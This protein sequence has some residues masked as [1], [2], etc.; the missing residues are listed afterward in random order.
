MTATALFRSVAA[1]IALAAG[2][3]GHPVA[4]SPARAA[5]LHGAASAA[6]DRPSLVV[7]VQR[8]GGF[9]APSYSPPP[10]FR[11]PAPVYR[12]PVY[13]A[14][15]YR[16]PAPAYRP[17][18]YAPPA[19][20]Y[21][22]PPPTFRPTPPPGQ[23]PGARPALPRPGP[24]TWRPGPPMAPRVVVP[25]RLQPPQMRTV[26]PLRPV[27][28]PARRIAADPRG[29]G[30][31][32][33][34]A[35]S[36]AASSGAA[37]RPSDRARGVSTWTN[38]RPPV[39]PQGR[40][41]AQVAP[42]ARL[43][44]RPA[45]IATAPPPDRAA[46]RASA[47]GPRPALAPAPRE[48]GAATARLAATRRFENDQR[49]RL[50]LAGPPTIAELRR[51][52]RGQ[53]TAAGQAL[54][55]VRGRLVVVRP[56]LIGVRA[57]LLAAAAATGAVAAAGAKDTATPPANA[58]RPPANDSRRLAA[59]D[60]GKPA[61]GG[62][63]AARR[64]DGPVDPNRL[65][66]PSGTGRTPDGMRAAAL[67]KPFVMVQGAD[68][69]F[70][71]KHAKGL[72]VA[73]PGT[74]RRA[75][76]LQKH[77]KEE[78]AINRRLVNQAVAVRTGLQPEGSMSATEKALVKHRIAQAKRWYAKHGLNESKTSKFNQDFAGI[79]IRK[80][81]E[82]TRLEK[83]RV[84]CQYQVPGNPVGRFF[85]DC[86]SSPT[87]LGIMAFGTRPAEPGDDP[88]QVM[89]GQTVVP[90]V[91]RKFVLKQP[92]PDTL[93]SVAGPILETWS[94]REL[95]NAVGRPPGGHTQYV[96]PTDIVT[97]EN[98]TDYFHEID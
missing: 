69:A 31:G 89:N 64:R 36:R 5:V 63:T 78:F 84:L 38:A 23:M 6:A 50:A 25:G 3:A 10:V 49:R 47:I 95:G 30:P 96:I 67:Q 68:T 81:V 56:S 1:L 70:V 52:F 87:Q 33:G 75:S 35:A 13:N 88:R 51:G 53:F 41:A 91:Q 59:N 40:I 14:P 34:A 9:R 17:P 54:V 98:F 85:A 94:L 2:L 15:A 86:G 37:Q 60:Q 24:S 29:R 72:D 65:R 74:S 21:R 11:A 16:P 97:A 7:P 71:V 92:L 90:K 80:T 48:R 58:S 77:Q 39:A 73:R 20:S 57:P 79:D 12:P 43:P 46:L 42:A 83:G 44:S 8:G 45:R 82:V 4:P 61:G 22:P 76:V 32:W 93:K 26:G 55:S 19:P 62:G 27:A 28:S 66:S 18:T